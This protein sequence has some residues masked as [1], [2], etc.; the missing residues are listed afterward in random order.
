VE[1]LAR[2][3]ALEDRFEQLAAQMGDPAIASDPD[4]YRQIAKNY[5]D[6]E[7]IVHKY[8]EFRRLEEHIRESGPPE[9]PEFKGMACEEPAA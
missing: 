3:G 4:T 6:L 9:D 1:L 8:R 5:S 7:R 2:L